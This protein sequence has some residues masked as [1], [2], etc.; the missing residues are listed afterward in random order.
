MAYIDQMELTIYCSRRV[1]KIYHPLIHFTKTLFTDILFIK[2][3]RKTLLIFLKTPHI[4]YKICEE[5]MRNMWSCVYPFC[6][7]QNYHGNLKF[8]L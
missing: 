7:I 1:V 8:W 5:T 2:S 6:N 3:S 4:G